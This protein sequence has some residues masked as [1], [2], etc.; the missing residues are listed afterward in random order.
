MINDK[1]E[2]PSVSP[3]VMFIDDLVS[4]IENGKIVLPEF[5]RPYVWKEKDIK[6]LF[7][8][9]YKGYPIGS[10]LLWNGGGKDIPTPNY[11]GGRAVSQSNGEKYYIVDGQQRLTTLFCCLS[12]DI[13]DEDGKWDLYFN[14]REDSFT[15][16]PGNKGD[17]SHFISIKS[18]RKTTSF[19]K[20]AR[21]IID[22]TSDD[23]LIEKAEILADKIRKYKMAVI[24]L[25]GGDLSEVVE[26]FS[27]LNSM[28]KNIGQQDIVYALTYD[29]D[30]DS[31]INKFID[32]VR[33][34]FKK[35]FID[36]KNK[37]EVYL[38]LIKTA[39]G[40]EVYDQDRNKIVEKL[41]TINKNN[42][43]QLEKILSSLD[44]TLRFFVDEMLIN[45]FSLLPY[46]NILFMAFHYFHSYHGMKSTKRLSNWLFFISIYELGRAS[47][48]KIEGIILFF[49]E[50][51]SKK[52]FSLQV[53]LSKQLNLAVSPDLSA[54]YSAG[55]ASGKTLAIVLKNYV[56]SVLFDNNII[57][58]VNSFSIFPPQSLFRS[59]LS[60]FLGSKVFFTYS[61]NEY[62]SVIDVIE[63]AVPTVSLSLNDR[64]KENIIEFR[65]YHMAK[66]YNSFADDIV[67]FLRNEYL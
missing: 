48:S 42:P 51:L 44:D 34:C 59:S 30:S 5:Q 54:K 17:D 60:N 65:R 37:N 58:D 7:D 2:I 39:I 11:V 36:E 18:L 33:A 14:L 23:S 47:P 55:S 52:E 45:K 50:G 10:I 35:Y 28:G 62:K 63:K 57:G 16:S 61:E 1:S 12:D 15:H 43:H 25:D 49:K 9:I 38:Q 56:G 21:R 24:K 31:G 20:E 8:S 13:F 29:G 27:R 67:S 32:D 40:F 26:V 64:S 19:L 3:E 66:I 53:S 46:T 22:E 6:Y 4:N 41:K